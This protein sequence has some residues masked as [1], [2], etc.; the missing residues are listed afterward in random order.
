MPQAGSQTLSV[1]FTPADTTDYATATST[2]TLTVT[3]LV[4]TLTFAPIPTQPEGVAPFAVNATS[5]SSGVVT[6]TVTSGPATI[7]GNMVTVTGLGTVVL[8]ANQAAGGNYTA[9]TA[10]ISFVVGLPFTLSPASGTTTGSVAPGAAAIFSLTLTPTGTT[11]PDAIMFSVTGLPPG[12]T[13]TFSPA[14]IAAG[15]AVT[16]VTLTIQ[17]ANTTAR[18]EQPSSGNPLAP[19]ALGFLLLPLLGLKS[20]RERLRQMPRL[21]VVLLAVGISLGAALGIS[22]C[23]GGGMT[24]PA[25]QSYAVVVTATDTVNNAQ[26]VTNLTLTVQ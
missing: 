5:V 21:P 11:F 25:A 16:P 7:A 19:V 24:P 20:A 13:A 26:S 6:Y 22:G 10:T 17:T 4:P 1:T 18:N 23:S 9:A 12:A 8:T 2:V 14:T 3:P 15:S